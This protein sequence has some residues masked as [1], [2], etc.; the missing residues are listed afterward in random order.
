MQYS[1]VVSVDR[2]RLT[3]AEIREDVARTLRAHEVMKSRSLK[4]LRQTLRHM[5]NRSV[6]TAGAM[7]NYDRRDAK[8]LSIAGRK[9]LATVTNVCQCA[10]HSAVAE[11]VPQDYP[12]ELR[13]MACT[14]ATLFDGAEGQNQVRQLAGHKCG[15]RAVVQ[16]VN[17]RAMMRLVEMMVARGQMPTTMC[18]YVALSIDIIS[19]SAFDSSYADACAAHAGILEEVCDGMG[20]P[21]TMNITGEEWCTG[22]DATP[23]GIRYALSQMFG[24]TLFT[25]KELLRT[26]R[27]WSVGRLHDRATLA[28]A[29]SMDSGFCNAYAGPCDGDEMACGMYVRLWNDVFDICDDIAEHEPCNVAALCLAYGESPEMIWDALLA[30]YDELFDV[31]SVWTSLRAGTFGLIVWQA[32]C[33]RSD[34][35]TRMAAEDV[36]DR[37]T[38]GELWQDA[39]YPALSAWAAGCWRGYIHVTRRPTPEEQ[40]AMSVETIAMCSDSRGPWR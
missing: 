20:R 36:V 40:L 16:I 34:L 9:V 32:W 12:T 4:A 35:W 27:D 39:E 24:L 7:G 6:D 29:M 5:D 17:K 15:E 23:R 37:M 28:V 14:Y 3:Y 25:T 31:E 8:V 10:V 22:D 19:T 38:T 18:P 1:K 26:R 13:D 21:V 2:E 33:F 30:A 11:A